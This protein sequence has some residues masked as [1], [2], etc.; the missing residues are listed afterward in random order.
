MPG[1]GSPAPGDPGAVQTL[2]PDLLAGERQECQPGARPPISLATQLQP[3]SEK[4]LTINQIGANAGIGLE[5]Q[6]RQ[7]SVTG[8]SL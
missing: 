4:S 5:R 6:R 3:P 1:P 7:V 2:W 8:K